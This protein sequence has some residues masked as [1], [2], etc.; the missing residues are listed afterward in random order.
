L[1]KRF[2]KRFG[3]AKELMEFSVTFAGEVGIIGF[4]LAL[5]FL[6]LWPL[7]L[8]FGLLV[9]S[10]TLEQTLSSRA[11]GNSRA[12][13]KQMGQ[14]ARCLSDLRPSGKIDIAGSSHD[15]TCLKDFIPKG[16][17]VRVVRQQGFNLV[18]EEIA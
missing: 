2:P 13:P 17:R 12:N 15:A 10:L 11:A 14:E 4:L 3:P 8:I 6:A 5:V 1:A 7:A 18:V 9:P 16:S